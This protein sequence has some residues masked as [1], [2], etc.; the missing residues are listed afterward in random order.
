MKKFTL[1]FLLSLTCS[2]LL[3]TCRQNK[4]VSDEEYLAFIDNVFKE[5][6]DGRTALLNA[7]VDYEEFAKEF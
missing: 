7:S 3:I 2:I 6:Y 4:N 5:I 1:I